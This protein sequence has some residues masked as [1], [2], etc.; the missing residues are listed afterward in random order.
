MD[1][2]MVASEAAPFAKTGGLA[3]VLGSLP[4]ALK[5]L[6]C[7]VRVIMPFYRMVKEGKFT[8]EVLAGNI[9]VPFGSEI[10]KG[11]LLTT[12][13]DRDIPA[14]FIQRD[15]FFDRPYL[16]GSPKGD[17]SDN[18]ER[19]TFFAKM[20]MVLPKKINFRPHIIHAHDW[21]SG[22]VPAYLK[23]WYK[24]DPFSFNTAAVYTIHNIAYQG[25]FPMQKFEITG[26]PQQVRTMDGM[27]F[28]GKI[29]FMKA[30][31]VYS[32]IITTVS[33]TYSREIQTEESGYG[34]EGI[35]RT[36]ASDLFGILNG[37][38]YEAWNPE[39]DPY[40]VA[41]YTSRDI[42]GK[43]RCKQDLIEELGLL[44]KLINAPMLGIVSRLADQKGLDLLAGVMGDLM[45]MDVGLALLGTGDEKYHNLFDKIAKRYPKKAGIKIKFDNVLAHKIV[46]GS[47]IL[48][49]PSRYEPCGLNQMY[50]LKYGTIPLVR[51]TGGL[52][53]TIE[54]FDEMKRT[55]TGFKFKE[56][57]A[58]AFLA[59][60]KEATAVYKNKDLWNTLIQNA[61][62]KDF[63]WS[64][65]AREYLWLY[66]KALKH[67]DAG[68]HRGP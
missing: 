26:L 21:Q 56:Y 18:A 20:A 68:H 67:S 2:L 29:N 37:V 66:N 19:Y 34:L 40:I 51:T 38:D 14:Y 10:L 39:T 52:G 59:K 60:I 12:T 5:L 4:K 22:L 31:I 63:S 49:V 7:D 11:N 45:G 54:E 17:Y 46:A 55:G 3:D 16:Y 43:L 27:E 33:P 32:D 15:E 57:S 9:E 24:S 53:D 64:V 47:D 42:S 58:R 48:L 1:I 41:R 65:S 6:G 13:F 28:W 62:S 61:M 23:T 36:R 25:I 8:F 30:G 50:S 44:K 35:L